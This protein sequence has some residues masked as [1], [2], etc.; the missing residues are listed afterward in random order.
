[1]TALQYLQTHGPAPA[2]RIA[3]ALGMTEVCAYCELVALEARGLVS[4]RIT[5]ERHRVKSREWV[6]TWTIEQL[7]EAIALIT[8]SKQAGKH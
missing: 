2:K 5:H 6:A 8:T 7:R 3:F 4:V 1:M